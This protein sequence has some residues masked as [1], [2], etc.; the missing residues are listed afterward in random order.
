ME[1]HNELGISSLPEGDIWYSEYHTPDVKF[2]LKAE[3]LA[4]ESSP[5][6]KMMMLRNDSFGVFFTLDGFV[7]VTERDEFVY[8]E[9]IV[10]PAMAVNPDIRR[11]LII[12]GGDGGTARE[13]LRYA[14]IE[15]IDMVE[16]DEMVVRLCKQHLRQTA[17]AFDDPRLNLVIG[18]GLAFVRDAADNSY[19]LILVDSTD[20]V[21]PGEG[22]FTK[23]FYSNC[24][25]AL[26]AQGILV[27][28]QEGAFYPTDI[29]EMRRSHGKIAATF[30]VAEIYGFNIPSYASGYWYFGFASKQPHPLRDQQAERWEA[31]GLKTRYYNRDIHRAAFALPN[32][33]LARLNGED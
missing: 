1:Q 15:K 26:S 2:S 8:H 9:M 17:I 3:V 12:G 30:P 10:H 24:H 13:V 27:N 28:Q 4:W 32:Y 31:F 7:Q 11:V 23:E 21:G 16:I 14:Q 33:V 22:L 18:D 19:D 20:P 29:Y 5:F 6:Q 25:R